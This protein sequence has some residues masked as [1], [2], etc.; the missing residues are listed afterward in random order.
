MGFGTG[1]YVKVWNVT[2][3]GNY[4]VVEISYSKKHK[5]G[6]Y[7][8]GA[9]VN[10]YDIQFSHRFVRFV[11]HAHNKIKGKERN[12]TIVLKNIDVTNKTS[13]EK[14]KFTDDEMAS[15]ATTAGVSTDVLTKVLDAIGDKNW[16]E[17]TNYTVFDFD[18]ADNNN[19]ATNTNTSEQNN[20]PDV[21]ADDSDLPF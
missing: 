18:F 11:G 1:S 2:D 6:D 9:L 3:N 5:D 8:V 12:T 13:K 16:R 21:T 14:L 7:I 15:I 17:Y 10:G 4:S 20:T 19:T